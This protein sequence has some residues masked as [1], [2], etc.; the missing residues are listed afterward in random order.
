[1]T[2]QIGV[3]GFLLSVKTYR[4]RTFVSL[5]EGSDASRLRRRRTI[6]I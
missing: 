1:M 2:A 3:I 4:A 6:V 5:R